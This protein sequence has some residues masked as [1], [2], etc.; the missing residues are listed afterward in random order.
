MLSLIL[1]T[2]VSF[3]QHGNFTDIRLING[4][5]VLSKNSTGTIYYDR[6]LDI[7][8]FKDNGNWSSFLPTQGGA[9]LTDNVKIHSKLNGSLLPMYGIN[10]GENITSAHRLNGFNVSS[11]G[12]IGFNHVNFSDGYSASFN[13]NQSGSHFI[14]LGANAVTPDNVAA[15]LLLGHGISPAFNGAKLYAEGSSTSKAFFVYGFDS[16]HYRINSGSFKIDQSGTTKL[17]ISSAGAWTEHMTGYTGTLAG[18]YTLDG[19][20]TYSLGSTTALTS[21]LSK[22]T[23]GF[24]VRNGT[25][26]GLNTLFEV[27][28]RN[29]T[30]PYFRI[31]DSDPGTSLYT[32][33]G[34]FITFGTTVAGFALI[35]TGGAN[36]TGPTVVYFDGNA[37]NT[38]VGNFLFNSYALARTSAMV[39]ITG[40]I[41]SSTSGSDNGFGL[42]IKTELNYNTTGT[43]AF[44]GLDYDPLLTS[45]TGLAQHGLRMVSGQALIGG[46]TLTTSAL[47]DLQ[48]TTRAFIPPRMTTTQ[49]D[50]ITS[51][52]Q[53]MLIYNTTTAAFNGYTSS[54]G[55]IGGG[56]PGGSNTQVQFNNSG[57]FGGNSNFTINNGTGVVTFGQ[58]PTIPLTPSATTD[59]ASKGYVDGLTLSIPITPDNGGTGV[60]NNAASTLTISGAFATTLTVSG[61]TG[62]T[63]PTTGTLATLAGAETLSSKT[64]TAPKFVSGGFIAD[65]NGNEELIFTTTASAVNEF[66]F[67]NAATAGSGPIM[68]TTGGDTDIGFNLD[69]KGAGAFRWNY[70][71]GT[72]ANNGI[73]YDFYGVD[74][75]RLYHYSTDAVGATIQFNKVRGTLGSPTTD[76]NGDVSGNIDFY[77]YEPSG[78]SIATARIRG[79]LNGTIAANTLPTDLVFYT[80]ATNSLVEAMRIKSSGVIQ[81]GTSSTTGYV[82]TASDNLGNGGWAAA[83]SGGWLVTG[84]TTITGNTTQTGAFK[85]TFALN[86][87][88][89][90]QNALSASWIPAL[91]VT[92]GAHTALTAAT[93]FIGTD[94]AAYTWTWN[95]GTTAT[96]RFNYLRAPTVNSTSGTATFTNIYNLYIEPAT[97][98]TTAVFTNSYALG[99]N[100]PLQTT[101]TATTAGLNIV[102]FAGNPSALK[103]GDI[104][105]NSSTTGMMMRVNGLTR[106]IMNFSG[107]P[108]TPSIPFNNVSGNG[109]YID[110]PN[111]TFSTNRLSGTTLYLTVSASTATA[112]TAPIKMTSGTVMTTAEAGAFEYDGTSLFFT[113]TGTTRESILTGVVNVVTP[114]APNRTV[115]VVI[116]GTTYYLAAKT[117]ND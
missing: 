103:N 38:G 95:S 110:S 11:G 28:G 75:Q 111:L 2:L 78:G 24:V 68:K 84:S 66:T 74:N 109:G 113:R 83:A 115:S 72:G 4:D 92:Q 71:A 7:F 13:T 32:G 93:E 61:T 20:Q 29:T 54:W 9:D 1:C 60:V 48:S 31:F 94:F 108:N 50:A 105:Y 27:Q 100:G 97:I 42:S 21:F 104:W 91:K 99:L 10:F 63:L 117:T 51:P 81:L 67:V 101:T 112:G 59:A 107:T 49:R 14:F 80:T 3:A 16:I 96:Q 12:P 22:Q 102:G 45:V 106:M 76:V 34:P 82:W 64:L 57:V 73:S 33:T 26:S 44:W 87:I 89:I 46:T 53:G 18:A 35:N 114:T 19:A 85:N 69:T 58:L 90:T 79:I 39:Q 37:G 56:T 88:E 5:S 36:L 47:L 65:A 30:N 70:R 15:T 8:R 52:S 23:G 77:T 86:G 116:A 62:V 25:G 40:K 55:A 17:N 41:T 43:H 6:T 98:G